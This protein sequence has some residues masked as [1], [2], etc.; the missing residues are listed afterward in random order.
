MVGEAGSKKGAKR[1][2]KTHRPWFVR[3]N[4]VLGPDSTGFDVTKAIIQDNNMVVDTTTQGLVRWKIHQGGLV[5]PPDL[6]GAGMQCSMEFLVQPFG[7]E[8]RPDAQHGCQTNTL[9]MA[10]SWVHISSG[11]SVHFFH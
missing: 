1:I 5:Q 2:G 11:G 10:E 8:R 6:G 9:H 7:H 3:M 4:W